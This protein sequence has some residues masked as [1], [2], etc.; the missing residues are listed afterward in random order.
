[1]STSQM[2]D[3]TQAMRL[4]LL[5]GKMREDGFYGLI[6]PRYDAHMAEY[7]APCDQRLGWVTSF[8]GSASVAIITLDEAVLFIVQARQQ[9][10]AELFSFRHL[11]QEPPAD[12]LKRLVQSDKLFGF[13]PMHVPLGWY[14][15]WM[16]AVKESGNTLAATDSNMIDALWDDRPVASRAQARP[17]AAVLCGEKSRAKCQRIAA[18]LRDKQIRQAG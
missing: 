4:Q 12:W 16:E 15:A 6:I 3:Q 14:E 17:F 7:V 13:D 9:C 2:S 11:H 5:R 10:P 18:D 1:M 8:T